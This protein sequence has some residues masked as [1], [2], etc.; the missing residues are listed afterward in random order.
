MY[1]SL[2]QHLGCTAFVARGRRDLRRR[3]RDDAVRLPHR[4]G[5][6]N[7]PAPDLGSGRRRGP[8]DDPGSGSSRPRSPRAAPSARRGPRRRARWPATPL[9]GWGCPRTSAQGVHAALTLWNGH[10][11]PAISGTSI[12]LC[13]RIAHVAGVAVMFTLARRSR[14]RPQP[15][16]PSARAPTWTRTWSA[17]STSLS[18]DDIGVVDAYDAVQE[19]EPDPVQLVD[20]A[21]LAEVARTFGDLADLKSPSLHGHSTS[22]GD[23]AHAAA[24]QRLRLDESGSVR[25]R[26]LPPRPRQSRRVQRRVGQAG[27]LT[28]SERDQVELHPYYTERILAR[29]PALA[30]VAALAGRHHERCD[31]SGYHRGLGALPPHHVRARPGRCRPLPEPRGGPPAPPGRAA[32]EAARRLRG[33]VRQDGSTATRSRPCSRPPDTAPAY[34]VRAWRT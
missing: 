30:D 4:L 26:R 28:A 11:T 23:L 32:G 34:A 19:A 18:L 31:G 22:V 6:P 2:L 20:D 25:R 12:P 29:V 15:S 27:Q 14:C 3:H 21:R 24:A 9:V 16:S 33:D 7:R 17:R 13:T 1:T 8:P 5:G 10:G